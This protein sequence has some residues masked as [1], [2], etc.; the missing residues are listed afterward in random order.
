M[1]ARDYKISGVYLRGVLSGLRKI[2]GQQYPTLLEKVG[3]GHFSKKYPP[4]SLETVATGAQ[5]I[6]M[7][8]AVRD[9]IGPVVFKFF[10]SNLG[11]GFG[12]A[13]ATL[14][15]LQPKKLEFA[16]SQIG[17]LELVTFIDEFHY[18]AMGGQIETLPE[19]GSDKLTLIFRD[20]IYCAGHPLSGVP[21]CVNVPA[22]YKQL[23][24]ELTGKRFQITETRCGAM[25]GGTDCYFEL[26]RGL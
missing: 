2:T 24:L 23:L 14:P 5:L 16:N 25:E 3:L 10:Y 8:Q 6:D 18:Q 19:P 22:M 15:Q 26:K 13:M 17:L 4:A 7:L 11:R 21:V 12:Q 20:C 9:L 1:S